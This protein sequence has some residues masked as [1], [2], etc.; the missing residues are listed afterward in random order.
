MDLADGAKEEEE[1][2]ELKGDGM[3][4]NTGVKEGDRGGAEKVSAFLSCPPMARADS[5]SSSRV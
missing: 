1:D 3:E 2:E 4:E 5:M